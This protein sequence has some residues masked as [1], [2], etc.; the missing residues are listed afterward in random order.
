MG[1]TPLDVDNRHLAIVRGLDPGVRLR[2]ALEASELA[3]RLAL[4]RLRKIHP[5]LSQRELVA[6]WLHDSF[7]SLDFP[8]SFR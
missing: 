6:R 1:D 8:A 3:R 7:P 5:E 4:T 2:Q